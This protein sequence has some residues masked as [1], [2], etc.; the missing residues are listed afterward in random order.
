MKPEEKYFVVKGIRENF[1]WYEREEGYW[2]CCKYH[3]GIHHEYFYKE[4]VEADKKCEIY[5]EKYKL[6][7]EN[8]KEGDRVWFV[9][10]YFIQFRE[11]IDITNIGYDMYYL[12]E[13][14][15]TEYKGDKLFKSKQELLEYL[16]NHINE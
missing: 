12:M 2:I 14:T 10:G 4:R 16:D 9:N 1:H 5:R 6:A 8:I 7:T 11:V 13:G 3:N 15:D